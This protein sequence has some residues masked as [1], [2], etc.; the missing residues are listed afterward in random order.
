MVFTL[1]SQTYTIDISKVY[2]LKKMGKHNE[3]I[4]NSPINLGS[5][6]VNCSYVIDIKKKLPHFI[7]KVNL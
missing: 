1:F 2:E 6:I 7:I 5:R 3:V 4:E